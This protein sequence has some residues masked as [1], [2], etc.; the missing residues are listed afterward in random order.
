M[1]CWEIYK[2]V[3]ERRCEGK[4]MFE[5]GVLSESG[6]RGRGPLEKNLVESDQLRKLVE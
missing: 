5:R 2:N 3:V 6:R 4:K 1:V